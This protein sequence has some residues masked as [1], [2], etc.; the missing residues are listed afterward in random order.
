MQL[1]KFDS[2]SIHK[3]KGMSLI[4]VLVSILLMAIIGLGGA[5]IAGR[6]AVLHRDQNVHLHTINQMR[7]NL[8]ASECITSSVKVITVAD[9]NINLDCTYSESSYTVAAFNSTG[10]GVASSTAGEIKVTAPRLQVQD[11][12]TFVPIK[13]VIAP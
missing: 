5:F 7:Y 1:A 3:Q 11:T 2:R 10:A 9:Q 4:E 12:D 8:E 6:T 13:I